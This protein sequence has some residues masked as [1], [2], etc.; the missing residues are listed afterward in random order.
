MQDNWGGK[1]SSHSFKAD[2][3]TALARAGVEE[4]QIKLMGRWKSGAYNLYMKRGRVGNIKAQKDSVRK[5][6]SGSRL[7][8]KSI[9]G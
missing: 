5:V 8:R 3:A 4:A 6:M 7:F 2:L 1:L 9:E